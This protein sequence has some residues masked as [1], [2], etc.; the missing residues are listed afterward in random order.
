MEWNGEAFHFKIF[1]YLAETYLKPAK[2][3]CRLFYYH[4]N[5]VFCNLN[6]WLCYVKVN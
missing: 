4:P 3:T 5:V 1:I 2:K 6:K